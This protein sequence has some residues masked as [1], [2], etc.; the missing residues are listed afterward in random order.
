MRQLKI[1]KSITN[2]DTPSLD[3]YFQEIS[4]EELLTTLEEIELTQ[5]IKAGDQQALEK[6]VKANLRFVVSVAKQYQ[7]RW[8]PL[9]DLINEGNIG[10]IKAAQKFDETRGFKFI[11]YAVRRIRQTIY[12]AL[13]DQARIVRIP[14]N[15]VSHLQKIQKTANILEQKFEREPSTEEIAEALNISDHDVRILIHWSLKHVSL[16]KPI[17]DQDNDIPLIDSIPDTFEEAPDHNI[18]FYESLQKELKISMSTLTPREQK[19]IIHY[20]WLNGERPLSLEEISDLLN[21]T[22]ERVRQI[23]DKA[24]RRLRYTS[25]SKQLKQFLG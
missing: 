3:K 17:S 15:Q 4:K 25:R 24:I 9:P 10:L 7:N 14:F 2:R 20:F 23:K 5:K 13:V 6:L 18:V 16:D 11:S 22:K 12:Q 1:T 8:V 19:I 21:I